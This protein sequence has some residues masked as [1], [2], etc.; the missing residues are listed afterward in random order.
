ML[1]TN[2]SFFSVVKSGINVVRFHVYG[3]YTCEV[4]LREGLECC[5]HALQTTV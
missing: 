2:I 5:Y 1:L 4:P 3:S